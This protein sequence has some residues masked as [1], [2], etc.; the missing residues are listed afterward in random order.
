MPLWT[1]VLRQRIQKPSLFNNF[2][3][4]SPPLLDLDPVYG[5]NTLCPY[6]A[7]VPLDKVFN[8]P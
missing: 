2:C 3:L 1:R 7:L 4:Q 8:R 5:I 6:V